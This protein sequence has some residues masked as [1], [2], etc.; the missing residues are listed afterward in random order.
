MARAAAALITEGTLPA[1]LAG[2][3]IEAT[4]LAPGRLTGRRG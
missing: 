4:D 1:D 2:R 3:G